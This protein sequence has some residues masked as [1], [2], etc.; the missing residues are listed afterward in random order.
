[1][2]YLTL[3]WLFLA[4]ALAGAGACALF[5]VTPARA[6]AAAA[7]GLLWLMLSRRKA[8][9]LDRAVLGLPPRA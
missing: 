5:G 8:R 6:G 4:T 9:S 2:T 1:M 3:R 7:C